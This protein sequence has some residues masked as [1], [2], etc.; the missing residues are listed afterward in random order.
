MCKF[1]ALF[2]GWQGTIY[3]KLGYVCVGVFDC[4]LFVRVC[5]LC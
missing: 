3:F 4:A 1:V 2:Y 5:K